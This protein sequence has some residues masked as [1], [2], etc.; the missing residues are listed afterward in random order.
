MLKP[1]QLF[2]LELNLASGRSEGI[3]LVKDVLNWGK[4]MAHYEVSRNRKFGT[5]Q[6]AGSRVALNEGY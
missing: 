5:G 1:L 6:S 2:S 3:T 4:G